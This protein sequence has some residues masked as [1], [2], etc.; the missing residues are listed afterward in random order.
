MMTLFERLCW[1]KQN[2]PPVQSSKVVVFEDPAFEKAPCKILTPSPE[3]MACAMHGS[4]LP[5]IDAYHEMEYRIEDSFGN[6]YN[7]VTQLEFEDML[8]DFASTG[9][10]M[11]SQRVT[12]HRLHD[13]PVAA[14][15]EGE[16]ID[17]IIKKD[18]PKRV[19]GTTGGNWVN[20]RVVDRSDILNNRK[21]RNYWKLSQEGRP[22]EVKL[23][24][25]RDIRNQAWGIA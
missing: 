7:G 10:A 23:P 6:A 9:K 18:T 2:I 1:A 15:T 5:P 19:W 24:T 8:F 22:I 14:L 13:D 25:T 11:M 4:I 17:Y 12:R 20:Y 3:W 21:N 16:A